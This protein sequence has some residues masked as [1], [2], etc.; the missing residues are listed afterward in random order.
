MLPPPAVS[1]AY[2]QV[3][4]STSEHRILLLTLKE[5]KGKEANTGTALGTIVPSHLFLL[6]IPDMHFHPPFLK[7]GKEKP[8]NS[9]KS[10]PVYKGDRIGMWK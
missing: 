7:M 6:N 8:S 1:K 3:M 2:K 5:Q 4:R 10:H 9:S